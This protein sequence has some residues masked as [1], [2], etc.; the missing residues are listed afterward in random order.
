MLTF[1]KI[2]FS[3]TLSEC[4][5]VWIQIR[6]DILSATI[7]IQVGKELTLDGVYVFPLFYFLSVNSGPA[8]LFENTLL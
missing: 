7:G 2:N 3:G 1:L 8:D 6:T 4:Q 5:S